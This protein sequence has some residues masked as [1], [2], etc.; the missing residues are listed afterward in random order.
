M[1]E[2]CERLERGVDD[3]R[4]R[5][6]ATSTSIAANVPVPDAQ[7]GT[8]K[9]GEEMELELKRFKAECKRLKTMVEE[10]ETEGEPPL[11][12]LSH[13]TSLT[14]GGRTDSDDAQDRPRIRDPTIPFGPDV[15]GKTSDRVGALGEHVRPYERERDRDRFGRERKGHPAL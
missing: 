5:E 3:G 11:A 13:L 12:S 14:H 2:R 6:V 15:G 1:R 9:K 10:K 4:V 8:G 7:T